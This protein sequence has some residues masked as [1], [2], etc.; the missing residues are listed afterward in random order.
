M[1]REHRAG[2]F[3]DVAGYA[4]AVRIDDWIAVSATAPTDDSGRAVHQGDLY[5]QTK[6]AFA[7]ALDA[8]EALGGGRASVLRTRMY[9][10]P[11]CEWRLAVD[12]HRELFA[13]V[14]PANSTFY[15]A[16]FIPEGVL[17]EVELDA[18]VSGG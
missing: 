5:G 14:R 18:V 10:V 2:G 4:R 9:L 16:G 15:V 8:V 17:V 11:G 13:E 1:R 12:A 6:L 7:R 3:E